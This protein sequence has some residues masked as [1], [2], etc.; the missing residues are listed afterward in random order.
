MQSSKTAATASRVKPGRNITCVQIC[1]KHS[2]KCICYFSK[3]YWISPLK[4][5]LMHLYEYCPLSSIMHSCCRPWVRCVRLFYI[6]TTVFSSYAGCP[7][8]ICEIEYK[9]YL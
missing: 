4:G 8:S 2:I 6:Y 3:Y 7:V 9:H 1:Q 5:D